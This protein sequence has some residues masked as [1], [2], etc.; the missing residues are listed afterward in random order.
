[1][2]PRLLP[3]VDPIVETEDVGLL[4]V[5]GLARPVR[6]LNVAGLRKPAGP[7]PPVNG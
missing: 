6:V 5:K 3:E 1:M 2:S 7:G 4:T